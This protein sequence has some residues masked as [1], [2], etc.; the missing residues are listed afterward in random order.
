MPDLDPR[1]SRT[2]MG[3]PA[4]KPGVDARAFAGNDLARCVGPPVDERRLE[5]DHVRTEDPVAPL[6]PHLVA[7][8]DE[9]RGGRVRRL[10]SGGEPEALVARTLMPIELLANEFIVRIRRRGR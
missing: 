8:G 9:R 7:A 2:D 5:I 1:A 4:G 10:R 6:A 3:E